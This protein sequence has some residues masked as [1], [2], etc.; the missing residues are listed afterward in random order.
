MYSLLRVSLYAI[1][2]TRDGLSLIL[3]YG[4]EKE[5]GGGVLRIYENMKTY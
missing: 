5:E 4:P 2:A 3:S 1:I